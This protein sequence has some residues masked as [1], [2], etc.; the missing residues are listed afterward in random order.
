M[1]PSVSIVMTVFNREEYLAEAIESVLAQTWQDFEFILWDDGSDKPTREIE[2]DYEKRDERIR[3]VLGEHRGV[4]GALAGAISEARGAYIGVIDSDDRLA[5]T[6]LEET[7]AALEAHP[8]VG[9]VYTDY[10]TMDAAGNDRGL[11]FSLQNPLLQG[12]PPAGFPDL[13]LP[14]HPADGLRGVRRDQ[15][16]G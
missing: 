7:V 9:F 3:L 10:R 11:R 6:A 15:P 12:P 5:P 4:A 1:A 16:R 14:P 13:P 2:R 8:Q